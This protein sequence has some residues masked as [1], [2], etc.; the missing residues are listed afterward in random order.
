MN[1]V[2]PHDRLAQWSLNLSAFNFT[3]FY[4]PGMKKQ[5]P[6]ALYRCADVS[7]VGTEEGEELPKIEDGDT[8]VTTRVGNGTFSQK[9][10]L[11]DD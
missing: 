9:E 2:D 11:Y 7:Q 5:V 3:L 1:F 10:E 8:L 4:R 6:E